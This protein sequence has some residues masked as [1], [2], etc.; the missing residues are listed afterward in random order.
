MTND[1]SLNLEQMLQAHAC[2]NELVHEACTNSREHG[3]HE[4]YDDML[5]SIPADQQTAL[6]RTIRL[7]KL[8]LI[9]S[10]IGE[11]VRALQHGEEEAFAE[12][13]ADIVIRVMDLCGTETIDLGR[14]VL[15]KMKINRGRP[16][17]HGKKC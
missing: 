4:I 11:A 13:V 12:E 1:I 15:R 8:A 17:L 3:F 9:D 2:L 16:Y 5:A 6:R 7:A 14:E 10:E